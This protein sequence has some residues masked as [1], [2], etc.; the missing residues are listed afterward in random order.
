MIDKYYRCKYAY[1]FK[2]KRGLLN[3]ILG[4]QTM[5]GE[6]IYWMSLTGLDVNTQSESQQG[7]G[8]PKRKKRKTKMRTGLLNRL[9]MRMLS[10]LKGE[11]Y[12]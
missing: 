12:R 5:W 6:M 7:Q 4:K 10:A 9:K 8:S 1:F 2:G 11:Q 3:E